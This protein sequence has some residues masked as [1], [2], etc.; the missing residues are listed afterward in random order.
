MLKIYILGLPGGG[1]DSKLI[2]TLGELG[3]AYTNNLGK[4]PTEQDLGVDIF[5]R[6]AF[7]LDRSPS[8]SGCARA[9]IEGYRS[10][11]QSGDDLLIVLED[12]AVLTKNFDVGLINLALSSEDG[13]A[14]LT[15]GSKTLVLGD[16]KSQ[17]PKITRRILIPPATSFAYVINRAAAEIAVEEFEKYGLTGMSDWPPA[18]VSKARFFKVQEQMASEDPHA[19]TTISIIGT[20]QGLPVHERVSAIYAFMGRGALVALKVLFIL[21]VLRSFQLI[22]KRRS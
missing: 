4:L 9:H 16:N 20:T 15:L 5:S 13:P 17:L 8:Q 19:A 6:A 12:D 7:G 18:L 14:V 22:L 1:R 3:L 11:L 10:F 2:T 21:T